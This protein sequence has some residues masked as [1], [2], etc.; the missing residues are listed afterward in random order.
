MKLKL[1]SPCKYKT[2]DVFL[3]GPNNQ[4]ILVLETSGSGYTYAELTT[5]DDEPVGLSVIEVIHE[6]RPHRLDGEV[7]FNIFDV[8]QAVYVKLSGLRESS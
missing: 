7:V 3:F 6:K 2:G 8:C 4:M 1:T 5:G